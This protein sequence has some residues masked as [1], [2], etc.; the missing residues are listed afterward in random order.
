MGVFSGKKKFTF[1][2]FRNLVANSVKILNLAY[3]KQIFER[4]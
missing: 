3:G 2:L 4:L 1:T